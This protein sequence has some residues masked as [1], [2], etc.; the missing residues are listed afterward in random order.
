MDIPL[1]SSRKPCTSRA[2]G[3]I[4]KI[5]K[6]CVRSAFLFPNCRTGRRPESPAPVGSY[7]HSRRLPAAGMQ[8]HLR[9]CGG[10][11]LAALRRLRQIPAAAAVTPAEAWRR[12]CPPPR[13][14]STAGEL[15][16]PSCFL[17]CFIFEF[18]HDS[19]SM[20]ALCVN[21]KLG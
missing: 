10:G 11:A 7:F 9:R 3:G 15:L 14:Y 8:H 1:Y 4:Y 12:P 13:L 21:S 2:E 20:I 6:P 5:R 18:A 19:I 17:P 16:S